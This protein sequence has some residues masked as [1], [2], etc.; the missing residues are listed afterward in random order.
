MIIFRDRED[1]AAESTEDFRIKLFDE[2]NDKM[3]LFCR[4]IIIFLNDEVRLF[5]EESMTTTKLRN[6]IIL[7]SSIE[8]VDNADFMTFL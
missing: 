2:A 3:K 6:I 7:I 5:C 4:I 8:S 1:E